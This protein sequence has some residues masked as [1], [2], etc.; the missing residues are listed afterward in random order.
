MGIDKTYAAISQYY[1][2]PRMNKDIRK[3][4]A[5]CESCQ[6]NKSSNQQPTGLLQPLSI[7]TKRWEQ[8]TMDFIVQLPITKQKHDA[9]VVFVD[10]LTK[11]AHY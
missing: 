7:P 1:F 10:K 9:I 5:S 4:I 3:Y 6:R 8:V 11:R 2:W